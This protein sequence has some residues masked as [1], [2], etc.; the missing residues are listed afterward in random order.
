MGTYASDFISQSLHERLLKSFPALSR[1]DDFYRMSALL[2]LPASDRRDQDRPSEII[3]DAYALAWAAGRMTAQRARHF[4]GLKFLREFQQE[5][6]SAEPPHHPLLAEWSQPKPQSHLAR[7]AIVRIP[8][9]LFLSL[10][11]EPFSAL[12]SKVLFDVETGLEAT[13]DRLKA[14]VRQRQ[15]AASSPEVPHFCADGQAWL[16]YLNSLPPNRFTC[17]VKAN[18]A[19]ARSLVDQLHGDSKRDAAKSLLSI[20]LLPKPLYRPS[21]KEKT[22]RVQSFGQTLANAPKIIRRTILHD[23]I[24]LDLRNVMLATTVQRWSLH[25]LEPFL[26]QATPAWQ[27]LVGAMGFPADDKHFDDIKAAVKKA[28]YRLINLSGIQKAK[29]ELG[30]AL[31]T[32]DISPQRPIERL[33]A[34]TIFREIRQARNDQRRLVEDAG[35][36]TTL[37]G[38]TFRLSEDYKVGT[39]FSMAADAFELKLMTPIL[40]IAQKELQHIDRDGKSRPG[41]IVASYEYDGCSILVRDPRK[42]QHWISRLQRAVKKEAD[43]LGVI[44]S[45][46]RKR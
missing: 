44:T 19:V 5:V 12:D 18:Y 35:G 45:L 10:G 31:E 34:H 39:L 2:L 27:T 9:N 37:Y 21:Q 38:Q 33:F 40:R 20:R 4:N 28:L 30:A 17:R 22:Y 29:A 46:E 43:G 15:D 13:S 32:L 25:S 1:R 24:E 41:F 16:A 11:H 42:A 7:T 6:R 14:I 26:R 36:I 23:A 3:I 8:K